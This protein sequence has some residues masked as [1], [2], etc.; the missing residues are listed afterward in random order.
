VAGMS[1]SCMLFIL[2]KLAVGGFKGAGG[3]SC[4]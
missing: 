2:G 3:R 1:V 4:F